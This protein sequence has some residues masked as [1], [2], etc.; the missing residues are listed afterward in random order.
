MGLRAVNEDGEEVGYGAIEIDLANGHAVEHRPYRANE[1]AAAEALPLPANLT[2]I[3][4]DSG[5]TWFTA[6]GGISRFQDGQLRAW[7][8]NDGLASELVHGIGRGTDGAPWAAT[9]LGLV[10]W[11]G[12][13]WRAL[14]TAA[15]AARGLATDGKGR[16]WVAT[17]KGLRA[18]PAAPGAELT[19]STTSLPLP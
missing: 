17:N 13:N 4:F 15:L 14:G 11:D 8:E 7:S 18:I 12:K 16:V 2:G 3:L 5:A 10:R 6:I 9:S 1:H 19:S